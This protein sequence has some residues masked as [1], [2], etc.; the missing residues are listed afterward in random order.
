MAVRT[1]ERGER[2][3]GRQWYEESFLPRI[4]PIA[5][6]GLLFTVVILFALQGAKITSDPELSRRYSL[7]GKLAYM[8]PEQLHNLP[9]DRRSDVFALGIILFEITTNTRLFNGANDVETVL[10]VCGT[11]GLLLSRRG[12]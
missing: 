8:S 11:T 2:R 5:L 4:G 10:N 9:L 6:Y 1:L 12:T 7:K 3:R